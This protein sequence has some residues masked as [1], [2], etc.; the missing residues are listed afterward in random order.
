MTTE[1]E[2]LEARHLWLAERLDLWVTASVTGSENLASF[3]TSRVPNVTTDG[4]LEALSA[5]GWAI[6]GFER[7]RT[8]GTAPDTPRWY[9]ALDRQSGGVA[10]AEGYT[11]HDALC[12]AARKALEAA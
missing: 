9:C 8:D 2:S 12:R 5:A 1:T 3:S 6:W 11:P 10:K 7:T 4:L